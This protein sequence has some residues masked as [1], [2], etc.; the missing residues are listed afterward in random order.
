MLSPGAKSSRQIRHVLLSIPEFGFDTSFRRLWFSL[1]AACTVDLLRLPFVFMLDRRVTGVVRLLR[2]RL[3]L[4][5]LFMNNAHK[6]YPTLA[7]CVPHRAASDDR[8]LSRSQPAQVAEVFERLL[9]R[10][11]AHVFARKG[12]TSASEQRTIGWRDLPQL[13]Q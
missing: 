4:P 13:R 12:V 8:R 1:D 11:V 5:G 6:L 3:T 7:R 9:K 2:F 10:V